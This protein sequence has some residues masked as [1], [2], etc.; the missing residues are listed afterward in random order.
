MRADSV[1]LAVVLLGAGLFGGASDAEARGR[2]SPGVAFVPAATGSIG[3]TPAGPV[4]QEP[5][6][7]LAMP[8]P[9]P[10]VV[11]PLVTAPAPVRDVRTTQV[12]CG[13]GRIVG[14]GA[15]FCEIN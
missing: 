14:S 3:S 6:A 11:T 5:A 1:A 8:R 12:W 7:S 4:R 2:R 10:S 13:S 15:G 9:I